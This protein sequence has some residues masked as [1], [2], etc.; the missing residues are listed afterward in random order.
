MLASV[1]AV[2]AASTWAPT[3]SMRSPR[4]LPATAVLAD[5]RVLVVGGQQRG[6]PTAELYD[7]RTRTWR[8]VPDVPA[9]FEQ[10]ATAFRL[11]NS[12]ILVVAPAARLSAQRRSPQVS[13]F[14]ADLGWL[15]VPDLAGV[16]GESFMA[17][18]ADP[19]NVLLAGGNGPTGPVAEATLYSARANAW[20]PLPPLPAPRAGGSAAPLGNGAVLV[21]G[22]SGLGG[23]AAAALDSA[24]V[25]AGAAGWRSAASLPGLAGIQQLAG[26]AT[27]LYYMSQEAQEGRDAYVQKRK[28]DFSKFPK[29]P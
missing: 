11:G 18:Q 17:A 26:D 1:P 27:L 20:F 24:V 7:P 4:S 19:D 2:L 29:R 28:P 5:G 13:S 10:P 3:G 23:G 21:A 14:D 8:A 12:R 9:G 16:G 15:P 25:F 6:A 22:G